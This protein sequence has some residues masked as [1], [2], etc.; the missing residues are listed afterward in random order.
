MY[1]I[2]QIINIAEISGYL[3]AND[4]ARGAMFSQRLNPDLPKIL[5]MERRAVEFMYEQDPDYSTLRACADYLYALCG[6]YAREA[7]KIINDGGSGVVVVPTS[8]S[9]EARINWIRITSADF[10]TPTEYINPS[11]EGEVFRLY[12]NWITRYLEPETEWEYRDGGGFTLLMDGIDAQAMDLELYL[13]L[14]DETTALNQSVQWES[15][16]GKPLAG[17]EYDLTDDTLITN[18]TG[19]SSFS[20]ILISIIPNG[21][22]YTWDTKFAFSFT[23]P[24]QPTA[25]GA[26]TMQNYTFRYISS[27]DK[28][29]CEGQSIDIPI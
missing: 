11:L 23:W 24:E 29:V 17:L 21:Y 6:R 3:A 18:P 28:W 13:D 14:R 20:T 15:I 8:P 2:P 12:A 1:T 7:V 16:V 22:N 27:Q 26:G 4:V 5:Y 19:T 10:S 25:T 9:D